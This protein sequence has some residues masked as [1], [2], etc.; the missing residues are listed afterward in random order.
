MN[1]HSNARIAVGI[2]GDEP[3]SLHHSSSG[4]STLIHHPAQTTSSFPSITSSSFSC[5]SSNSSPSSSSYHSPPGS[6]YSIGLGNNNN[7]AGSA[8][9][10][11]GN[12]VVSSSSAASIYSAKVL[13]FQQGQDPTTRAFPSTTS[14]GLPQTSVS[15]GSQLTRS[16]P[17]ED[18]SAAA[19]TFFNFDSL[20]SQQ[21]YQHEHLQ[22]QHFPSP[23]PGPL[24]PSELQ[25]AGKH[26][27]FNPTLNS[28]FLL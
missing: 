25:L 24:H 3:I 13:A 10:Q 20:S 16:S 1:Y 26:Q 2:R 6:G 18:S 7:R 17:V 27:C 14:F 28:S 23:S 19:D 12:S 21:P 9:Q 22:Q 15:S 8:Q 4:P 11:Y 5:S